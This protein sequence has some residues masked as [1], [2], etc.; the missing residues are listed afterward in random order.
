MSWYLPLI[1]GWSV[2]DVIMTT[3]SRRGLARKH[4]NIVRREQICR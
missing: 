3:V 1:F 2:R 4:S